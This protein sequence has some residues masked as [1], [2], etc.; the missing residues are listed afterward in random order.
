MVVIAKPVSETAAGSTSGSPAK[1]SA[2]TLP[3]T[4][5][6]NGK[7]VAAAADDDSDTGCS[8]L[9]DDDDFDGELALNYEHDFTFILELSQKYAQHTA[10]QTFLVKTKKK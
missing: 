3:P 5:A 4:R 7:A 2:S 10:Q 8:S 9:D 1:V 6:P